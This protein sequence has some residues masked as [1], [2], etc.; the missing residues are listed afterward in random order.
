MSLTFLPDGSIQLIFGPMFSGKTTELLRR[1][2]RE[3]IAKRRCLVV[4]FKKDT[5]YSE[6]CMSTH[7]RQM[8]KAVPAMT[9]EPLIEQAM[10]YD[11]IG[12]DEG[13]FF[14]DVT[15]FC[16]V[17]ANAGKL[18]IVA[19]L[20]G[21]FQRKA[22]GDVINLVPMAESILK[23]TAV[24]S[25]CHRDAH[26]TRRMTNDTE[27]ELIGGTDTYVSVCRS[28]FHRPASEILHQRTSPVS[29]VKTTPSSGKKRK[30]LTRSNSGNGLQ[31]LI[32]SS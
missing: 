5:R 22:F 21:T 3:T 20:D 19:S 8:W 12:I 27:V 13:Q 14:P 17:M 30:S 11:V 31:L 18:V 9:L 6:D 7:D 28:C 4:K 29:P 23:L 25:G 15:N 10:G 16:E 1:I 24:C 32:S 2:R 26:F